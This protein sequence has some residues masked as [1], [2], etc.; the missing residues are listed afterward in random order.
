MLLVPVGFIDT[1]WISRVF[2]YEWLFTCM[3]VCCCS[4]MMF[5][6]W[7]ESMCGEC[8]CHHKTFLVRLCWHLAIKLYCRPVISKET[9]RN[10]WDI[11]NAILRHK[12]L[13]H[14]HMAISREWSQYLQQRWLWLVSEWASPQYTINCFADIS[15]QEACTVT[16]K[17][18]LDQMSERSI[19]I[20]K[21]T[22]M[23]KT[24]F[25]L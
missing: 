11:L 21:D 4:L 2:I 8:T 5:Y 16:Q 12:Y 3:P 23:T 17:L 1:S 22:N 25:L 20:L 13:N 7:S 15:T 10:S 18:D 6:D 19:R 24:H 14:S 9:V